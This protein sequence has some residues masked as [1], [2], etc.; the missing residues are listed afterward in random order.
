[1]PKI[2]ILVSIIVGLVMTVELLP[3]QA[4]V[5]TTSNNSS[6]SLVST[7]PTM[8]ASRAG[9]RRRHYRSWYQRSGSGRGGFRRGDGY[10]RYY[11]SGGGRSGFRRHDNH[12]SG[13]GR[14]GFRGGAAHGSNC[15]ASR[16]G[17][18]CR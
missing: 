18:I 14:G 4:A 6:L 2:K 15:T 9:Y 10:G 1:M 11:Q 5:N 12:Q 13:G 8:I 3:A 7:A 17:M 16:A